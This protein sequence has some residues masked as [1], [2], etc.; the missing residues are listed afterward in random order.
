MVTSIEFLMSAGNSL[1]NSIAGLLVT[2]TGD[3]AQRH[4]TDQT[5]LAIEY[6]KP[7]QLVFRHVFSY[8]LNIFIIKAVTD[9]FA[10]DLAHRSVAIKTFGHG[11]DGNVAVCDHADQSILVFNQ[12][13][14]AVDLRHQRS[15]FTNTLFGSQGFN[16]SSH[17]VANL[18]DVVLHKLVERGWQWPAV[19]RFFKHLVVKVATERH[20]ASSVIKRGFVD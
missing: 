20:S 2:R 4:Y 17:Y 19:T 3:V 11:A 5:F 12:Q 9:M 14:S 15:G 8:V 1:Q 13:G 10:H 18:H 7:T 6:R 16:V